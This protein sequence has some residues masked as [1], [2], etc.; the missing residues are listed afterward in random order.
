MSYEVACQLTQDGEDVAMVTM[1]D[2]MSWLPKSFQENEAQ[3]EKFQDFLLADLKEKMVG[4]RNR[5]EEPIIKICPYY[6]R[7]FD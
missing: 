2:T 1:L 6:R 7:G 4:G 5:E 3:F